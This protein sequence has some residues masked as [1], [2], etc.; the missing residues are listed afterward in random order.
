MFK[1]RSIN[2]KLVKDG[3]TDVETK[4][5]ME[6]LLALQGYAA[7]AEEFVKGVSEA[8]VTVIVVKTACDV[9]KI[10]LKAITK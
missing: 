5:P 6:N 10:G 8:V 7:I 9:V 4:D 2:V 3:P 1:N